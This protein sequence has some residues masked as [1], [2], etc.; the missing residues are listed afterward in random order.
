M[1]RLFYKQAY[2]LS[3]LQVTQAGQIDAKPNETHQV[4]VI[5]S[6]FHGNSTKAQLTLTG[7]EASQPV[8]SASTSAY[9]LKAEIDNHYEKGGANVFVPAGTLY[10]DQP[11]DFQV[12]NQTITFAK[13]DIPL[14]K[15]IT[16][17]MPLA[18]TSHPKLEQVFIGLKKGNS[19]SYSNTTV[20]GDQLVTYTRNPGTYVIAIDSIAP[21]I[22]GF[23]SIE[24]KWLSKQSQISGTIS[25][26]L[27]G[28]KSY[29]LYLNGQWA[30][31]D[32]DYKT[33][34]IKHVFHADSPLQEGRNE[35]RIV[36]IDNAGNSTIFETHF[37]RS[38]QL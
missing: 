20:K 4:E 2:P 13:E 26:N 3:I 29:D 23:E 9:F 30:L 21:R 19:T 38:Q 10:E 12:E 1:Q 31:L 17:S 15:N 32:Y 11:I 28:I 6:D 35:V 14:H 25:D 27:S 33:R 5:L 18:W 7:T 8:E 22:N 36:V 34:T 16:V 24:G 37:F